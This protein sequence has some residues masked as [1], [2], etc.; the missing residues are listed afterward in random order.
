MSNACIFRYFKTSP[1]IFRMA[2]KRWSRLFGQ[3]GGEVKLIL[4]Y[5]HAA[6]WSVSADRA[7]PV[8]GRIS[9]TP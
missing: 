9:F 6:S 5:D 7:S 2:V 1:E 4:G 3:F 8:I